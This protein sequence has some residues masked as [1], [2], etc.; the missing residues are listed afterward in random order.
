MVNFNYFYRHLTSFLFLVAFQTMQSEEEREKIAGG[1]RMRSTISPLPQWALGK[2]PKIF[3]KL[4]LFLSI[5]EAWKFPT[6]LEDEKLVPKSKKSKHGPSC[7]IYY[8]IIVLVYIKLACYC[9]IY[10]V[11]F[12]V[13]VVFLVLIK[14]VF[15]CFWSDMSCKFLC[16]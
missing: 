12:L 2:S 5:L 6:S 4:F 13:F 3:L 7:N 11:R 14:I 8:K 9:V 1:F 15:P 16:F 10:S